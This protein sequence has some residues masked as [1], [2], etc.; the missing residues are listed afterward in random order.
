MPFLYIILATKTVRPALTGTSRLT[1]PDNDGNSTNKSIIK[2]IGNTAIF[3]LLD[4]NTT[5]SAP[6]IAGS[7][8]AN[9]GI[10]TG[11]SNNSLVFDTRS[12]P[13]NITTTVTIEHTAMAIVAITSPSSVLDFTSAIS[14]AI[15]ETGTFIAVKLPVT[16]PRYAPVPS[17][18]PKVKASITPTVQ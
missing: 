6:N 4:T 13:T 2:T 10:K 8:L 12:M 5:P 16:K 7:I 11:D 1:A 17:I 15:S 18:G 14:I 3:S 9:A